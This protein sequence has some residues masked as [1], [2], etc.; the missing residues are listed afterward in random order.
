MA[1]VID[2][3]QWAPDDRWQG[4]IPGTMLGAGI[5]LI[6]NDF[7][8][9]GRG[10][11]LHSHPYPETFIIK[12]GT[13]LF[14]AGDQQLTATAGQVLTVPSGV[15]HKFEISARESSRRSTSMRVPNL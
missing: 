2:K 5:C 3:S 1:K 14:T 10:P 13:A 11:R 15:P 6:F 9:V 8:E 7:D 12:V 4:E